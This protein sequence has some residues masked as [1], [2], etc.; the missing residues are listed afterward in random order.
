MLSYIKM[1]YRVFL[2][3][4]AVVI[5][6]V[7]MS[8]PVHGASSTAGV[9]GSSTSGSCMPGLVAWFDLATIIVPQPTGSMILACL[10]EAPGGSVGSVTSP[11]LVYTGLKYGNILGFGTGTASFTCTMK[12]GKTR[13][14]P[15]ST[16]KTC[17]AAGVTFT[18]V[19]IPTTGSVGIGTGT[20][21]SGTGSGGST[22]GGGGTGSS[23]GGGPLGS[24][25]N[26]KQLQALFEK[27]AWS[28][29][30]K[31][32]LVLGVDKGG[33]QINRGERSCRIEVAW[34]GLLP[35]LV[36]TASNVGFPDTQYRPTQMA[37]TTTLEVGYQ[38]T[39]TLAKGLLKTA[40]SVGP[41]VRCR[42]TDEFDNTYT[43]IEQQ[44]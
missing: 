25:L 35:G 6:G 36:L 38:T 22:S 31:N 42:G 20:G 2:A 21:G 43:C 40:Q 30:T 5:I 33:C 44:P 13:W 32:E 19:I 27:Y 29:T 26:D 9:S 1:S 10:G 7:C 28:S 15:S 11:P 24:N 41:Y 16:N 14:V 23:G 3:V 39:V 17:T 8:V 18:N 34:N 37:G 4:F 12:D